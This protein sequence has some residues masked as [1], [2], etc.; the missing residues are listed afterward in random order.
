[1]KAPEGY[2]H[3][4]QEFWDRVEPDPDTDCLIYQSTATRPYYQGKSLLTFLT[5]GDGSQKHRACRRRMCANPDHIQEGHFS[6]GT[7]FA[8]RPRTRGQFDRQYSQC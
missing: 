7:P 8:K 1:M 4:G 2:E 6:P 3:L 5:G